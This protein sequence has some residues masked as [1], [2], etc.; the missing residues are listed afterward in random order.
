MLQVAAWRV[1]AGGPGHPQLT[2]QEWQLLTCETALLHSKC[3]SYQQGNEICLIWGA[4]PVQVHIEFGLVIMFIVFIA[5][6]I[7]LSQ[8]KTASIAVKQAF[9]KA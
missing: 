1:P 9:T 3:A 8:P 4:A 7:E 5:G 2:R 6:L